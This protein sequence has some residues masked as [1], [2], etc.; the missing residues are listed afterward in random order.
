MNAHTIVQVATVGITLENT[1]SFG[2][3]N[4][5]VDIT[6]HWMGFGLVK[7]FKHDM[8]ENV[9]VLPIERSSL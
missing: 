4:A 2:L 8:L 6:I 7:N 3:L 9:I 5:D 1:V